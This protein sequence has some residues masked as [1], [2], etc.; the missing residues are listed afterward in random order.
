[1]TKVMIDSLLKHETGIVY[2]QHKK[3]HNKNSAMKLSK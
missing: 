2:S 3:Q 1:M